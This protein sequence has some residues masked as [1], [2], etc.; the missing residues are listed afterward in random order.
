MKQK[1]RIELLGEVRFE[2][3]RQDCKTDIN[4]PL[5][6]WLGLCDAGSS[7][8][9]LTADTEANNTACAGA[10]CSTIL[11]KWLAATTLAQS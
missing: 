3:L 6:R 7:I 1:F 4:S 9:R 8:L 10:S 5:Q 11:Q 2:R